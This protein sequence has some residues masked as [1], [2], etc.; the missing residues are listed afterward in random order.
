MAK[1][2]TKR[3]TILE[4]YKA[5]NTLK[6][7]VKSLTVKR[8]LVWRTIKWFNETGKVKNRH[9]QGRLW[10]AQTQE[11]MK[12]TWEKPRKNMKKS[13]RNPA[14]EVNVFIQTMSTILHKDVSWQKKPLLS[15]RS[16]EKPQTRCQ[17]LLK[18]I[19]AGMLQNLVFSDEKM[20]DN[21]LTARTI[22]FDLA[23][24]TV[25]FRQLLKD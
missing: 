21:I 18:C 25:N 13:F 9:G 5:M 11:L 24:K 22:V 12:S 14:E 4:M 7:I 2:F 20:V 15:T 1:N 10:T 3:L 19:W 6:D 23:L 16:V 17:V 8:M